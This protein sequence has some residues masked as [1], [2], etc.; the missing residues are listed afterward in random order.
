METYG[1][2]F[3]E[4]TSGGKGSVKTS[5]REERKK[6]RKMKRCRHRGEGK[7]ESEGGASSEDCAW[8]SF[9]QANRGGWQNATC[10]KLGFLKA[11]NR[12]WP[13]SVKGITIVL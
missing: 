2:K 7:F 3:F 4:T 5:A 13:K 10:G 12:R 9:V 11:K 1:R 8:V 6:A